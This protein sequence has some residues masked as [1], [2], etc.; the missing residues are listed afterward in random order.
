LDICA[1][2]KAE[3]DLK[4]AELDVISA[5]KEMGYKPSLWLPCDVCGANAKFIMFR[6]GAKDEPCP[7]EY[8]ARYTQPQVV[9]RKH[10]KRFSTTHEVVKKLVKDARTWRG[11]RIV[12]LE[13]TEK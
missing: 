13:R 12:W 11:Y 3:L 5:M 6:K 2:C 1:N 4:N 7:D 9:C 8:V 10:I